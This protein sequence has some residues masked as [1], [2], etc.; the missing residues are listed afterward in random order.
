MRRIPLW[1]G[2]MNRETAAAYCDLQP[3]A[4]DQLMKRG[5]FP[6]P[7]DLGGYPRWRRDDVDA[8]LAG[9]ARDEAE[10]EPDDPYIQ[11]MTHHG[12]KKVAS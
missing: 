11:G 5:L 8:W 10:C 9:R 3:P 6:Q 2:W 7:R 12:T 1:P 4:I